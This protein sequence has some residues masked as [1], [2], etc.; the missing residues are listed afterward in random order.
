MDNKINFYYQCKRCKYKTYNKND[1]KRHVLRVN[2]CED[3]TNYKNKNWKN[4]SLEKVIINFDYSSLQLKENDNLIKSLENDDIQSLCKTENG[5]DTEKEKGSE[6]PQSNKVAIKCEFCKNTFSRK[7]SLN[8]HLNSCLIKNCKEREEL[9]K[10]NEENNYALILNDNNNEIISKYNQFK[11]LV[12]GKKEEQIVKYNKPNVWELYDISTIT[13]NNFSYTDFS[14]Y[15]GLC[16]LQMPFE[17]DFRDKHFS[18]DMKIRLFTSISYPCLLYEFLKNQNNVNVIPENDKTSIVY[19]K[20]GF[21]RMN[22]DILTMETTLKLKKYLLKNYQNFRDFHPLMDDDIYSSFC[23]SIYKSILKKSDFDYKKDY[24]K[25][26]E[27]N[28][29][30]FNIEEIIANNNFK[31]LEFDFKSQIIKKQFIYF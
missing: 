11:N 17:D 28:K 9:K 23:E 29:K 4:E 3:L 21:V 13:S 16:L 15:K 18:N 10:L 8:R 22:N 7:D 31:I 26:Y 1:M 5:N 30:V 24:L 12:E 19:K 6:K 27:Y 25:I 2:I 20:D 14:Y